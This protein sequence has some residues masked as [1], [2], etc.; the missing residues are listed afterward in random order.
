MRWLAL[1]GLLGLAAVPWLLPAYWVTLFNYIGLASLVV[2]GLCLLTGVA[3][4]LSF[5]QAAFVGLGAYATSVLSLAGFSP[6]IG[7]LAGGALTAA[8]ALLLGAV[9]LSLGGHFLPLATIAWG[10]SLFYLFGNVPGFGGFSGLSGIPPLS[11]AGFELR[12]AEH[13]FYL[14]WVCVAA[15]ALAAVRLLDSRPGRAIRALDGN[16][17]VAEA[18]GV[19]TFALKIKVFVLS[20]LLAGLSGWL[21]AH[22]QRFVN[23]TPFGLS[24]GMEYLFMAVI[25]G[26][27]HV[28]GAITG[29]AAVVLLQQALKD[30]L[31]GVLGASGEAEMIAFGLL[32][33][34]VLH[35]AR[36]G[37][38]DGIATRLPR[39]P[40]GRSIDESHAPAARPLPPKGTPLLQVTSARK[41]FGGLV[42]VNDVSFDMQ[43]GEIL[44]LIGPNGA[45][46]STLFNVISGLM[47]L[48]SG[49]VRFCGRSLVGLPAREIARAGIARTFQHV[50]LLGGRSVL[51][52]VA[53]GAHLQAHCGFVRAMLRFDRRDEAMLLAG[54]MRQ[55][56]R[57]G[58][59][60]DAHRAAASLP[61]GTQRLVEVARALAA[62]PV[63]LLL[64]EPAA[65]L[66]L[67][68][69]R[70]L[71]RML[72]SLR[73]EG[74][75]IVL[76]EHD[77]D[78]V[79][80]LTDRIVVLDFGV[81]LAEGEPAAIRDNEQVLEAYLGG[82]Q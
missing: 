16:A 58:L 54:A 26:A 61:L 66:R 3:G 13:F 40:K 4:Q 72:G 64:D 17:V 28:A 80:G 45:G 46:K 18:F 57:V 47:P 41:T 70:Q 63:L 67:Q 15:A 33:L 82:V 2:I 79:M 73:D 44:G 69:K 11:L 68:E 62:D 36:G 14:I 9:T 7:L 34:L 42:A 12:A 32:T 38:W 29:S 74:M 39:D 71:A 22:L 24:V 53:L 5:G 48:A 65:G 60:A 31:P 35:R 1:A 78:F 27:G 21:Y 23:P 51:E 81:K 6:W 20:A 30:R 8:V 19:S 77:M 76:V 10:I 59:E 37:L 75:S 56:R 55:I 25:G 52:N 50:R 43:A 49:D